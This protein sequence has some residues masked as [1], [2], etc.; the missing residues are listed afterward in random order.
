LVKISN[1]IIYVFIS[2]NKIMPVQE[3]TDTEGIAKKKKG[4]FSLKIIIVLFLLLALVSASFYFYYQKNQIKLAEYDKNIQQ[5]KNLVSEQKR[6]SDLLSQEGGN[7]SD[8]DYCRQLLQIF[9]R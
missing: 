7:F 1:I 5:I 8:Y 3:N 4:N 9:P 2:Y 6:C